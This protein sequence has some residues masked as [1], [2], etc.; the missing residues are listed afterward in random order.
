MY[1][2]VKLRELNPFIICGI[3]NGYLIDATTITECLHTC[4]YIFKFVIFLLFPRGQIGPCLS[5]F[6]FTP[7]LLFKLQLDVTILGI[8]A[9]SLRQKI[10]RDPL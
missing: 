9:E 10:G 2:T 3:C 1:Q 4:E 7:F 8:E 6:M 5:A